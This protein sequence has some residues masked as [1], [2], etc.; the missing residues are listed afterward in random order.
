[1]VERDNLWQQF[2]FSHRRMN[3]IRKKNGID[4]S[5]LSHYYFKMG[6]DEEECLQRLQKTHGNEALSRA[7]VFK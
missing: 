4:T 2:E 7:F 1:M 5:A 3:F 6:L